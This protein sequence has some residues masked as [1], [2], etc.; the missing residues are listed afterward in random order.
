MSYCSLEEAYGEDFANKVNPS[1]ESMVYMYK[2][3][4]DLEDSRVDS[5]EKNKRKI[6]E[7]SDR[8]VRNHK[9]SFIDPYDEKLLKLTP[10]ENL[11]RSLLSDRPYLKYT[12]EQFEPEGVSEKFSRYGQIV[13]SECNDFFYHLDTCKKCQNRLKKRIRRYIKK[14]QESNNTTFNPGM[15]GYCSNQDRELFKDKE[16][17]VE[18]DVEE[19]NTETFKNNTIKEGFQTKKNDI[20]SLLLM[21]FGVLVIYGLDTVK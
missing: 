18:E 19:E 17:D 9:K 16:E 8:Y 13:N 6:H 3:D 4:A 14:L 1:S 5:Y 7:E 2:N 21:I 15:I 20:S 11:K 10:K 12:T